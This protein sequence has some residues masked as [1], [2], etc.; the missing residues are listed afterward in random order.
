MKHTDSELATI[1]TADLD[2]VSGGMFFVDGKCVAGCPGQN[3]P[4][5]GEGISAQEL[6]RDQLKRKRRY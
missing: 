5:A 1:S 4:P 2:A 3:P 6:W